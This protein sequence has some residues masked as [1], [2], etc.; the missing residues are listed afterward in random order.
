MSERFFIFMMVMNGLHIAG[1]VLVLILVI[2][3]S[4]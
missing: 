1:W 4:V 3:E 2:M